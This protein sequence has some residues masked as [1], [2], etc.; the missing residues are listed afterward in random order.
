LLFVL[1]SLKTPLSERD[2]VKHTAVHLDV[3]TLDLEEGIERLPLGR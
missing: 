2:A 1:T 3:V